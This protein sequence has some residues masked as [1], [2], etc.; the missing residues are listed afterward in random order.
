[1]STRVLLIFTLIAA[2]L[3]LSGGDCTPSDPPGEPC[4]TTGDGF[5]KYDPCAEMCL[6]WEIT[7][8]NGLKVTP[9]VCSGVVCGTE[10]T[11]PAGQMCVQVDSFAQ[12]SRCI[13][14]SV[15][16]PGSTFS[17]EPQGLDD[18]TSGQ[19]DLPESA[20]IDSAP[21]TVGP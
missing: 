10:G 4:E 21:S 20:P 8:P 14:S 16:S 11:C 6:G 12:N 18:E 1:M 7:C 9:G 17:A 5:T 15:C 19:T 13:P 3:V 2:W